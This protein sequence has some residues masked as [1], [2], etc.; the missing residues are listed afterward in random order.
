MR[1]RGRLDSDGVVGGVEGHEDVGEGVGG[2]GLA[3]CVCDD[4]SG[5]VALQLGLETGGG[6]ELSAELFSQLAA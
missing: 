3:V 5:A 2:A 1:A 4:G 6:A